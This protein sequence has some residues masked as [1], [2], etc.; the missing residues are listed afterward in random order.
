MMFSK[1][2]LFGDEDTA[3]RILD[4]ITPKDQKALGRSV[5][6][7]DERV[8]VARREGIVYQANYA[9]FSQNKEQGRLLLSTN[10][11]ILVEASPFDRIWGC[12]LPHDHPDINYPERWLGLN[13]QGKSLERVRAQLALDELNNG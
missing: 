13:L 7:F 4:A 11:K 12:G 9:K 3:L 8:W 6:W 5:R 2:K 10:D 1:A